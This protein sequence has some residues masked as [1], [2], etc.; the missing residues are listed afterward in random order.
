[1]GWLEVLTMLKRL[2]PLLTRVAPMLETFIA[3]RGAVRNDSAALERV[4]GGLKSDLLSTTAAHRTEIE[5]AFS[6]QAA[7]LRDIR[8]E[9]KHLREE[10]ASRLAEVERGVAATQRTLRG[11]AIATLVLVILCVALLAAL[12]LR[13]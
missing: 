1:M 10:Q 8:V 5:A 9:L 13:H 12:L 2:V 11:F 4:A 7:E 6:V 3:T